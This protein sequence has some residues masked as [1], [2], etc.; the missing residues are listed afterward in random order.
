MAR[1]RTEYRKRLGD[2]QCVERN[3]VDSTGTGKVKSGFMK[4]WVYLKTTGFYM[5][6]LDRPKFDGSHK[7]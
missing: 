7:T 4:L 5:I 1:L 2:I 6:G 3:S